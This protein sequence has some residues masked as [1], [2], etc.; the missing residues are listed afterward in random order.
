MRKM[1]KRIEKDVLAI[2]PV[3]AT[4][5]LVLIAV[6]AAS[7]F[8]LWQSGWQQ[9]M[10]D[11]VGGVDITNTLTIAGSS[12]VYEFMTPAAADY[13]TENPSYSISISNVGS[14]AGIVAIGS[15]TCD[16]GMASRALKASEIEAYPDLIQTTIAYDGIVM[17]MNDALSAALTTAGINATEMKGITQAI[18]LDVYDGDIDTVGELAHALDATVNATVDTTSLV[19]YDRAD[20]SGTEDGFAEKMLNSKDF[21]KTNSADVSVTGNQG[22]IDA[23]QAGTNMRI[24]F[25][26][27]GMAESAD[28]DYFGFNGINPSAK[29]IALGVLDSTNTAA[30]DASRPLVILTNGEP[31][32]EIQA[33]INYIL[34]AENNIEFCEDAGFIS[35]TQSI[36]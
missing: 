12:T 13:M 29:A 9:D 27:F 21:F 33:F 23:M 6:A 5:M 32:G 22:M 18:A 36:Y 19:T 10:Q 35:Y 26:S 8:Y 15:G 17:V 14:G 34:E 31:T 25:A 2:S 30:Y 11:D 3:I 1:M 16:I 24:G 28:V 4:L 7:G 20:E